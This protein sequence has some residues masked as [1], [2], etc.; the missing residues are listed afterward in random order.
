MAGLDPALTSKPRE[1]VP[2]PLAALAPAKVNLTLHLLG[3]RPDGYHALESLVAFAGAG[4]ALTLAPGA[5]LGLTVEGPTGAQAGPAE[6]NL[7]LKAARALAERVEGLRWGAFHLVKRL[8]VAAGIGGGSSDAAAAL[9]LLARLNDLA[10]DHPAVQDAARATGSDVPVCLAARARMMTGAGEGLGPVLRLPRLF[11]VLVNPGV[12]VETPAVFGRLG[13][14]PGET[15]VGG[16]HPAVGDDEPLDR[17]L[18]RLARARNDL[19]PPARALAPAIEDALALVGQAPGCRLA[20]MSG[21]GATVFGLFETCR[22]AAAAAQAIRRARP[23]WW[24]RASLL[25]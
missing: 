22:A 20:R 4:D 12:P 16:P 13:L 5:A 1:P 8:P 14:R 7:I 3:R 6:D 11:A 21:S 9:R 23:E 19:E 24:A 10:L 17:L 15:F 25:R 2:H 18:E